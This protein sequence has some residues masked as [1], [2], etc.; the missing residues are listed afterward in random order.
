[1]G[2]NGIIIIIIIIIISVYKYS[3]FVIRYTFPVFRDT[4]IANT[5]RYLR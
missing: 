1:M 4:T 5:T 2:S 3:I